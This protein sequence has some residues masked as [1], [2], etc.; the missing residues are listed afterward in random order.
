MDVEKALV[1]KIVSTGQLEEAVARGVQADFFAD[2]ECREMFVYLSEHT[3]KYKSPPS[4]QVVKEE[5]PKFEWLHL[6]DP[7]DYLIDK[8]LNLVK[9][10]LGNEMVLEL[11]A[12]LDDPDRSQNID[13]E[14]LE[15]ARKLATVVPST[16]VSR[17]SDMEGRIKEYEQRKK[18]GKKTGLPT[19]FPQLDDWTGGIQPHEFWTI[20]GFSGLGKSTM[21]HVISFNLW[22]EGF[23]PLVISLEMEARALLRRFDA[24]AAALDYRKMKQLDL[25]APAMKTWKKKAQEIRESTADIPIIDSI[26]RCTPDHVF[27]EAVRHK[28]DVVIIDYLS[29]MRSSHPRG[30]Q[31]WQNITEIT[32]DLK[33]NART[34]KIPILAA[35]QT[36]RA[37]K[38]GADL[39]NMG[40]SISIVQDSDVV[41]GLHADD[42]MKESKEM[43]I[44]LNKN[45]DGRIGKTKAIW[46]YDTMQF[47][48]KT[49]KDLFGRQGDSRSAG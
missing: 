4:M 11:A 34:L 19:G 18:E 45:R 23:T 1:S 17:F 20:S 39:E 25:P 22:A 35:A 32:Q 38:D 7:L 48:E 2:D 16:Q 6:S 41:I 5:K 13:L 30:N 40:Y 31:M 26:R 47:R 27:A 29:L 24:M 9:R 43:E 28:P 49:I 42:A 14:F 21:L 15:V 33:Q 44:R 10:R 12:A 46:D 3:K 37:G 36:N 8:F